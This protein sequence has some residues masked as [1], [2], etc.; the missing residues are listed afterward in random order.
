MRKQYKRRY[1]GRGFS[2]L[3]V[4]VAILL[5]ALGIVTMVLLQSRALQYSHA[6]F[7]QGLGMQIA[8]GLASSARANPD[9]LTASNYSRTGAYSANATVAAPG[10]AC[11]GNTGTNCTPAEM[12]AAD[13]EWARW[14]ARQL[15]PGGDIFITNGTAGFLDVVM[16]WDGAQTKDG[17]TL[18]CGDVDPSV[19]VSGTAQCLLLRVAI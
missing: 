3:E 14:S 9:G 8:N 1:Q 15:L 5:I 17:V 7:Y 19:T 6:A 11:Y 4:L 10:G 13:I 18:P 12:A 2:L 16:V